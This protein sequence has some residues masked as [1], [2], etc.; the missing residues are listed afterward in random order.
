MQA[1]TETIKLDYDT[2]F[3]TEGHSSKG[4]QLKWKQDDRWIKADC[5]GYESVA[6]VLISRLMD[7]T[8]LGKADA[9]CSYVRYFPVELLL[10]ERRMT[11]CV[12]EN[13]LATDCE[14]ITL[15]HLHLRFTGQ[16][17]AK[18]LSGIGSTKEKIKYTVDFVER[19]TGIDNFGQYIALMMEIDA[20]YLN[21]DRHTNNIAIL[22]DNKCEKYMLCPM[23]DNGMALLSDTKGDY[24][25]EE[26]QSDA[27]VISLMNK[28]RAKP[29]SESFDDQME[30]SAELYGNFWG[31]E[32]SRNDFLKRAEH[33]IAETGLQYDDRLKERLLIILRQQS[34]KYA[35]LFK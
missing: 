27:T 30:A 25:F 21:E 22:Y 18:R 14:I 33:I 12:S 3:K 19:I 4:N 20:F 17:L 9:L 2:L 6:E 28:V 5:A 16:G 32:L 7:F 10:G 13:F 35:Y 11:G 23:F 24:P 26:K 1:I 15:E 29:F 34:R 8:T 31:F